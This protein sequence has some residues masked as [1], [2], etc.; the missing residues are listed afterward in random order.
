M[1]IP[2]WDEVFSLRKENKDL[3]ESLL[4]KNIVAIDATQGQGY[5]EEE[6]LLMHIVYDSYHNNNSSHHLTKK[7]KEIKELFKSI[8]G[9]DKFLNLKTGKKY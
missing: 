4:S 3:R 7:N 5:T 8:I 2:T 1:K 9:S 6:K